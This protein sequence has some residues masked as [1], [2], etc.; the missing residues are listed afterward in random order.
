MHFDF[1]F[2]MVVDQI[3]FFFSLQN[4]PLMSGCP[5]DSSLEVRVERVR[6]TQSEWLMRSLLSKRLLINLSVENIVKVC[7]FSR[8]GRQSYTYSHAFSP[9]AN[10][11]DKQHSSPALPH[12]TSPLDEI[13]GLTQNWSRDFDI[14]DTSANHLNDLPVL[15][16][17][18]WE[19][20]SSLKNALYCY[21][22]LC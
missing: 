8:S 1:F 2:K 3:G 14:I 13:D 4:V 19:P 12:L 6:H 9:L 11:R 17:M 18:F 22:M 15:I 20:F 21:I 10:V 7:F 5:W 16:T